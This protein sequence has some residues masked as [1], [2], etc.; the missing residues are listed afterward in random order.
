MSMSNSEPPQSLADFQI[1][2]GHYLRDPGRERLPHGIPERRSRV[3]EELLF[4]NLRG[5]IDKCFPVTASIVGAD[6]WRMLARDFYRDWYCETPIFSRIPHEFVRFFQ[7]EAQTR[8]LPS[9][10]PELAHYEWV[11]LEVELHVDEPALSNT[12]GA[13]GLK[14][15]PTLR[16]LA[17]DWPVHHISSEKIPENP[18]E[19]YLGVYRDRDYHVRF[20]EL[21]AMTYALLQHMEGEEWDM[22]E[23]LQDFAAHIQHPN[24]EQLVAF[25]EPVFTEFKHK[26]IVLTT[27]R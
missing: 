1:R 12:A 25:G 7:G 24:P 8:N 10:L 9:W 4:N 5:F 2:Y 16:L 19:T 21:N 22:R 15:N 13:G 23:L 17:Y 26:E 14:K 11:E 18:R 27:P 20:I 6:D 3:Y